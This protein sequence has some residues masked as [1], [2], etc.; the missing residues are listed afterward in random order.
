[1][2]PLSLLGLL[3]V[4]AL[5]ITVLLAIIFCVWLGITILL[6]GA[7]GWHPP[8]WIASP[9]AHGINSAVAFVGGI[10]AIIVPIIVSGLYEIAGEIGQKMVSEFANTVISMI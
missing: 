3:F 8:G 4:V 6:L 2:E 5:V 9:V 10:L 1:M 7:L